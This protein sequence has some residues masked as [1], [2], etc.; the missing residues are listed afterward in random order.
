MDVMFRRDHVSGSV[1][2]MVDHSQ[3]SP[4]APKS[5]AL[6]N[7]SGA[8]APKNH[9]WKIPHIFLFFLLLCPAAFGIDRDRRI[10]QLYH[11]GWTLKEGVAGAVRALAQTTDGYLWLGTAT[12]LYRF[13]GVQFER[14]EPPLGPP[15]LKSNVLAL[16]AVSD[17]GLWVGYLSGGAS[18]LKDGTAT[19]YS[20]KDG[21]PSGTITAFLRDG[22]GRVWAACG[23]SGLALLEGSGWRMIGTDWNFSGGSFVLSL[24][25]DRTG[26]LWVGTVDKIFSLPKGAQKFQI[27][28]DSLRYARDITES[29]DGTLWMAETDNA[30]RPAPV[31][32]NGRAGP[33]PEIRVGSDSILFDDQGSLWIG[34]LGDGIRRIPYPE[35]LNGR[36]I[37]QFSKA[38]EIFTQSDG[39]TGDFVHCLL[40][41]R[42][43]NVWVGTNQGL[44]CFRQS[45]IAPVRFPPGSSEF[46][47]VAG[48]EG[49]IWV[50]TANPHLRHIQ[51]GSLTNELPLTVSRGYHYR[52]GVNWF[53]EWNPEGSGGLY[54]YSDGRI[55][56]M[57]IPRIWSGRTVGLL[58]ADASGRMWVSISSTGDFRLENGRW[59]SLESLG[60]PSED[61]ITGCSDMKGRMWFGFRKNKIAVLDGDSVRTL[62]VEDGIAV[63][64]I[65]AIHGRGRDVWI[66]GESGVAM[67][68]GSRFW[69]LLPADG[70]AFAGIF[71][72]IATAD[73]GLWLSENRGVI[74]V[75]ETEVKLFQENPDYRV[76]YRVFNLLDGLSSD[77]QRLRN[78]FPPVAEGTDGRLW[79]ATTQGVVWIDP[80]RIPKSSII[81]PVAVNSVTANGIKYASLDSLK[82]PAR[83]ANLQIAYTALSLT[84][85]ERVRFRYRLEGADDDWQDPDTRRIAYYTNL[86]PGNYRF[87][88]I[89][90]NDDG[91][92]N[93]VGATL[94]FTIAPAWYQTTWF[95]MLCG[96]FA[97]FVM[98]TL[99][100]L[101]LRQVARALSVRFDERLA[102]RTRIARELHDTLLQTV[103]GSK[104]VADDALEKSDDAAYTRRALERLSGWLG[105]ATQE[106]RAALNSLRTSTIETNDLAAGLRRATEECL[107][108]KNMAVKFSVAGGP[109]AMHP[110]ARDEIYRIGYEAIRN[111]CEHSSASKL[112]VSLS[113]AQDLTLRVNDN[114]IGIEAAVVTEG[115]A[116]HFGLQGMRERAARIGSKLT[117]VSSPKSGTEMTMVVPGSII[118]RKASAARLGRIKTF[119]GRRDAASDRDGSAPQ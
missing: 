39:L 28:A 49:S 57:S 99:Y 33:Q 47:L 17:G 54:S 46:A 58:T 60:G 13:D 84:V 5:R 8:L 79:F 48:D 102:E 11:T 103:Q 36:R 30:V 10:D 2:G 52:D 91:V 70:Q 31:A 37:A 114:G 40:Q 50:G 61:A 98:W 78:P 68:D 23:A 9:R 112:E 18:F 45:V 113:Y 59:K 111:A 90:C 55:T 20:E 117:L 76:K 6:I 43:G 56:L 44:D 29:P 16:R 94:N 77:L 42:E 74:Q 75:P 51:D 85:P 115:K 65:L 21:L 38:A 14:Y 107:L 3:K 71:G 62:S 96:V 53:V 95:R 116:G 110:I 73:N 81:P 93:E 92:W 24:F 41:D 104:L 27:A 67:F 86:G 82:L 7:P 69:P 12:G 83:I 15:L 1:A 106:G 88:V 35:R 101:R 32:G 22:Q 19:N 80:N 89:A 119:L 72:V 108:D 64:N 118:F 109:R 34:S 97:L 4:Q 87:R 63:G 26:T 66:G 25:E 100:R 105:Q